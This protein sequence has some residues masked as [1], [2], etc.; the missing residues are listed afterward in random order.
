MKFPEQY[1]EMKRIT[2]KGFNDIGS[3]PT[4]VGYITEEGEAAIGHTPNFPEDHD[5]KLELFT[6]LGKS[7]K[8]DGTNIGAFVFMAESWR[9]KVGKN[10]KMDKKV[11]EREDKQECLL[12]SYVDMDGY[13]LMEVKD[14]YYDNDNNKKVNEDKMD[15]T[16]EGSVSDLDEQSPLM[17]ALVKGYVT[18]DSDE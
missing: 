6:K 3:L 9:A 8:E 15:L 12:Y 17:D 18:G 4:M 5:T 16:N 1:N 13:Y 11:S 2:A 14:I 10:E 7:F